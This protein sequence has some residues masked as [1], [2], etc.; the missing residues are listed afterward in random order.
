M[1]NSS[2]STYPVLILS[3]LD[4]G[5]KLSR[6]HIKVVAKDLSASIS[7]GELIC[8]LGPNGAG[9]STLLRTI[10]GMQSVLS[11]EVLLN[12]K[13]IKQLL[14]HEL[15]KQLSV[16]LTERVSVENL[17]AYDLVS[18]GRYPYTNW[19]GSLGKR[20]QK[21]VRWALKA[22]GAA[23]LALRQVGELSDGERQRVMVARALAQEPVLMVLDEITAF[24]DL[25]RRAEIMG[26]LREMAH[27]TGQSILIS[28]HDLEL[29]LKMADRIWLLNRDGSFYTGVP[30]DLVLNNLFSEVFTTEGIKFNQELGSFELNRP[31]RFEIGLLGDGLEAIWTKRALEREGYAVKKLASNR[32][33]L[34]IQ[35]HLKLNETGKIYWDLSIH[36]DKHACRSVEELTKRLKLNVSSNQT[37]AV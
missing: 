20:D 12:G 28:S 19:S 7:K 14:P 22:V 16:V 21:I 35:I 13:S 33:E 8:L 1:S 30:E 27:T 26:L 31:S 2:G 17:S 24:L 10:A 18:L 4:I 29:S 9:K 3:N 32:S 23:D 15:A 37:V 34:P 6:S 25:P 5:Y 36:G 11:G